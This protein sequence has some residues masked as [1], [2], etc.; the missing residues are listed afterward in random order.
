MGALAV[1]G[2]SRAAL[3]GVT[4]TIAGRGCYPIV[5]DDSQPPQRD[6]STGVLVFDQIDTYTLRSLPG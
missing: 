2:R 5:H 4:P 6:E 3:L 1:A